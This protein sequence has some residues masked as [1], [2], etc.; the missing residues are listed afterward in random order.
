MK[1]R[2]RKGVSVSPNVEIL[3]TTEKGNSAFGI[4]AVGCSFASFCL[5]C[6]IYFCFF[7]LCGLRFLLELEMEIMNL[8][9]G[10]S[11]HIKTE[12]SRITVALYL[13]SVDGRYCPLL[14]FSLRFPTW[15]PGEKK[16]EWRY[17]LPFPLTLP[18][19]FCLSAPLLPTTRDSEIHDR[20]GQRTHCQKYTLCLISGEKRKSCVRERDIISTSTDGH[21]RPCSSRPLE[22]ARCTLSY[23]RT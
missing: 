23:S 12:K 9:S 11:T 19:A 5:V 18:L 15:L 16:R 7:L 3:N 10:H 8:W 17:P 14:H 20:S 21:G 22:P 2:L 13:R 6:L 1:Y 4:S